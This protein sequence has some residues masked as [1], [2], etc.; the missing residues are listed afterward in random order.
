MRDL[1]PRRAD[2]TAIIGSALL[3]NA[4]GTRGTGGLPPTRPAAVHGAAL[5]PRGPRSAH[6]EWLRA[7]AVNWPARV[8]RDVQR[9][10]PVGGR[11]DGGDA[12][13]VGA[14]AARAPRGARRPRCSRWRGGPRHGTDTALPLLS[15]AGGAGR[16]AVPRC[17]GDGRWGSTGRTATPPLLVVPCP[18]SRRLR[19]SDRQD[20]VVAAA[21]RHP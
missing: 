4:R 20:V 16:W 17:I 5:D 7:R 18:P 10:D 6:V 12:P 11:G 3:A 21:A 1:T 8:D 9:D 2:T 13:L 14:R 15:P 19:N